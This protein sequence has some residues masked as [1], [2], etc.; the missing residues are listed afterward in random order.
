MSNISTSD[1]SYRITSIFD[2]KLLKEIPVYYRFM[3]KTSKK[4]L[5]RLEYGNFK[6]SSSDRHR[7]KT[8]FVFQPYMPM[9]KFIKR[10]LY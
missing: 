1:K 3:K 6:I 4:E 7:S 5:D 8:F 2:K 10:E 9:T